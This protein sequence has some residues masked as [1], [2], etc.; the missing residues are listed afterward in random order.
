MLLFPL[1]VS[2]SDARD[3]TTRTPRT[4]LLSA[5]IHLQNCIR[6]RDRADT[7]WAARRSE[8]VT[9]DYLPFFSNAMLATP[10]IPAQKVYPYHTRTI[11]DT[12]EARRSP[13]PFCICG[14]AWTRI[15]FSAPLT[16]ICFSVQQEQHGQMARGKLRKS[17]VFW[18]SDLE[19]VRAKA[20]LLVQGGE[21]GLG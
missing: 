6:L 17:E 15:D 9:C 8:F 1:G 20:W 21:A 14:D 2:G 13:L 3:E 11:L 19:E 5:R 12:S 10:P 7:F 16:T 18:W 4:I